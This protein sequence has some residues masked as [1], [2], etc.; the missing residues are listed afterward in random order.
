[1]IKFLIY[2]GSFDGFLSVVF[3][4]YD[5]RLSKIR[6]LREAQYDHAHTLF[7]EKEVVQTNVT[8]AK[9]V[10]KTLK[11]KC[12]HHG[13]RLIY[14]AYLSEIAGSEESMLIF[15]QKQLKASSP[16][17]QNYSDPDILRLSKVVKMVD[18]EKH[19]LDAFVRFRQTKEGVYFAVIS[20]DFNVLPLNISHFKH[21]YADQK[22]IIYDLKRKYGIYY[23][24]VRV[25]IITFKFDPGALSPNVGYAEEEMQFE[26]L[27]KN[28]FKST[29]ITSRKNTRLHHQ[30]VPKRYWKYLI[31]KRP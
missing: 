17:S 8:H 23:D 13:L 20:P 24:L 10:W 27:W 4:V 30:H 7:D 21:R 6:I 11:Q 19:R 16:I 15:I 26:A 29:N 31:E 12:S 22:W 18:R 1:M 28:Y 5:E 14:K 9:R 2:D 25:E 3:K